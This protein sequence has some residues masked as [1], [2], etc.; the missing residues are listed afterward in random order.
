[1][2]ARLKSRGIATAVGDEGGFAPALSSNAE[3]LDMIVQAIQ[4]AGYTLG[5][6]MALGLDVAS[7]ALRNEKGLY[8]LEGE[9]R[10]METEDTTIADSALGS[11]AGQIKT[12]SLNRSDRVSKYNRLIRLESD[13]GPNAKFARRQSSWKR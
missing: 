12:G 7:S 3:A 2:K 11:S 4:E 8:V 13:L 10:E 9:G 5:A 6:K 1:L